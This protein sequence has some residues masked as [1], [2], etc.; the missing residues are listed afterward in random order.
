[1]WLKKLLYKWLLPKFMSKACPSTICRSGEEGESVNCYSVK[2]DNKNST[3]F[4]VATGYDCDK[5]LGL[6]WNGNSYKDEHSLE[7][8]DLEAGKLRITHYYGLAEIRYDSIYD[9]TWHYL[10]KF[11]YLKIKIDQYVESVDQKSFNKRK[12]V[13]ADRIKLLQ[14]MIN[15]QLERGNDVGFDDIDFMTK[16]YSVNWVLHPDGDAAQRKL[17]CYIHWL[18]DLEE[19]KKTNNHQYVVTGLGIAT[20]EKHLKEEERH[21]D[22]VKLQNRLVLITAFLVIVGLFQAGVGLVQAKVINL[23]TWFDLSK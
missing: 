22:G 20:I 12:L 16:L 19:L 5:L 9:A 18:A 17:N 23:P 14:V 7:L 15:Y 21:K 11:I 1:M 3:P 10:T 13:I 8:A 4:F 2:L 6:K